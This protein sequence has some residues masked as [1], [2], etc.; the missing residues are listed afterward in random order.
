MFEGFE[1]AGRRRGLQGFLDRYVRP[2]HTA[3]QAE[4]ALQR[5]ALFFLSLAVI[6]GIVGSTVYANPGSLWTGLALGVPALA[7]YWTRSRTVA[8]I[9]LALVLVNALLHLRAPFFW[10]WV[11]LAT[12]VT[13]LAFAYQRLRS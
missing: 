4:G 12:R 5:I 7:L 2:P 9:L 1:E 6:S 11:G 13:Q 8:L 10:V 3:A